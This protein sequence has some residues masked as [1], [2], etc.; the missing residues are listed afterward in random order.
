LRWAQ[1]QGRGTP[2]INFLVRD[3]LHC[4][5]WAAKIQCTMF[6]VGIY[7]RG[8]RAMANI[9]ELDR[10][11]VEIAGLRYTLFSR[12]LYRCLPSLLP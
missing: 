4:H 8:F 12:S 3:E 7:A 10:Q 1:L 6:Q 9:L 2:A 11:L 5:G